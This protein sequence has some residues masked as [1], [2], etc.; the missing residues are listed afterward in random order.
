MCS[1]FIFFL[2][3]H[4][5]IVNLNINC[6]NLIS[7]NNIDAIMEFCLIVEDIKMSGEEMNRPMS[8]A[9][10]ESIGQSVTNSLQGNSNNNAEG[11]STPRPDQASRQNN[12][13][14]IQQRKQQVFNLPQLKKLLKLANYSQCQE[15]DCKCSGWKSTQT[16]AKS[17]KSEAQ[18][19]ATFSDPCRSCL[20]T[21]ENH[22]SHLMSLGEETINNLLGMVVDV[23]N[24]FMGMHREEDPDTKRVYYY[25]FKLL[26][27]SILGMTKPSVEGP[28]GQPPFEKPS[29]SKAVTNFVVYKF[30][31]LGQR[32]WQSMHDLAKMFLHCLN[33]WNFE[34][35]S[36]RKTVVSPD[37][38]AAYKINYTRWLV[39]CH[40]P[41]F[42]D[43][44]PHF[45]TTLVFGKTLLQAVFKSV[46]K[47]LMDKCHNE[48]ER[49]SA[50][51]RVLVLNHFPKY[52]YP[53]IPSQ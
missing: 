29:I 12:L 53:S 21:L 31:H 37:E 18:P 23:D 13:Q 44:L 34:S 27:K 28:L 5:A 14:R 6:I 40:V 50:E 32:E 26:R 7:I 2:L 52:V 51:K 36:A 11:N 43:S 15:Q 17:P 19:I 1:D 49:M 3:Q 33:H 47:Q 30:G 38:A 22:I 10:A 4:F 20:H 48:K 16:L 35:P 8:N 39:F 46:C 9:S 42:C 41:A 25:L 45:D 24:I